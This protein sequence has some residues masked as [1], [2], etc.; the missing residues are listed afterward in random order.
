M[1]HHSILDWDDAY[2]NTSNIPG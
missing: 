2:A 1:I